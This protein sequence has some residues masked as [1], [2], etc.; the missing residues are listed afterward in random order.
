[1]GTH[2]S[3][4]RQW[5]E[6]EIAG[7]TQEAGYRLRGLEVTRLD[8]FVDAAFAFVLTLLVIS[9]DEIPENFGEM[10][11][12]MKR[13][14]AFAVSFCLLMMYW[15]QH[16]SWSRRYGL[17]NPRTLLLSLALIFTVLVYVFPLRTVIA[18]MF[19][20]LSGGLLP[21]GFSVDSWDELRGLF[22]FYSTG[23]LAMGGIMW[24][25]VREALLAREALR[26]NREEELRTRA[27]RDVWVICVGV[28][29]ASIV[30]AAIVSDTWVPA[31]GYV[32][33]LLA[34]ALPLRGLY[35]ERQIARLQAA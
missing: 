4:G 19:S 24:L 29:L 35:A 16:R 22:L 7:L 25:L 15:L 33:W 18:G 28:G 8:T 10:V 3:A 17:E 1:M 11:E 6:A 34:V 2:A 31:A 13:I 14:P 32:Y 21:A 30:L 27:D 5:T 20:Q 23:F 9:F 26:L 12:A